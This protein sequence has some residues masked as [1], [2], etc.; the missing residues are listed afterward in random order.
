MFRHRDFVCFVRMNDLMTFAPIDFSLK[1]ADL[2]NGF[3][4]SFG[5]EET[6][7]ID[8]QHCSSHSNHQFCYEKKIELAP[9]LNCSSLIEHDDE[10]DLY[11]QCCHANLRHAQVYSFYG[12]TTALNCQVCHEMK[13][14]EETDLIDNQHCSNRQFLYE[15]KIELVSFSNGSSLVEDE[16]TDLYHQYCHANWRHDQ[17]Y[18]FCVK[19]TALNCQ[20]CHEMKISEETDLIDD[21]HC[22]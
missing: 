12:K 5:A 3:Q 1:M 22:S 13:I 21:Q 2:M 17:V 20:A 11:H 18:S 8:D 4:C 6:D 19:K 10:T 9:L 16:E 14:S 7:L 15:K